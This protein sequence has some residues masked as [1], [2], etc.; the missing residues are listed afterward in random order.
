MRSRLFGL[1]GAAVIAVGCAQS[2][3][4]I[5]TNVKSKLIADDMVK[6]R[7]IDVDTKDRV[8]TLTGE[9]RSVQEESRALELA[10]NTKGVANV[11]DN[12]SIVE[13][14]APTSGIG[15]P[16]DTG[17]MPTGGDAGLTSIVKTKLL[18]DPDIGGLK[19]DVDTRDNVVTLTGTV[20]SAAEKS[21][22]LD[23]ARKTEGVASVVDRLTVRARGE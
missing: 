8:V 11:V 18:A 15:E 20:N 9:V 19:I 1:I 3:A 22:A 21:K 7:Q 13:E 14:G 2:D 16:P 5:T 4:G 12:L 6:A 10:R 17:K 23:I